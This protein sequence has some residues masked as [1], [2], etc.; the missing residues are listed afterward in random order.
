MTTDRTWRIGIQTLLL[1]GLLATPV[2]AC[3]VP[4]FRYALEQWPP[5]YFRVTVAHGAA[6]DD[7]QVAM[8]EPFERAEKAGPAPLNAWVLRAE[9]AVTAPRLELREPGADATSAP[10]WEAPLSAASLATLERSP[11]RVELARRL[12]AGDSVVWLLLG[13][14]DAAADAEVAAAITPLL[15]RLQAAIDLPELE[16]KDMDYLS[17]TAP[18]LELRFSLL[19][20]ARADAAEDI[21]RAQILRHA[22]D[23]LSPE[24]LA[25][26][27]LVPVFGRGRAL[28]VMP[29]KMPLEV[30]RVEDMAMFMCGPCS[31]QVKEE[32]PGFDL[33]LAAGWEDLLKGRFTLAEAIPQLASP[34][35]VVP[36]AE[37]MSRLTAESDTTAADSTIRAATADTS[38]IAK[39]VIIALAGFGLA[40]LLG[41]VWLRTRGRAS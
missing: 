14:E 13:G 2:W 26:P 7:A 9:A 17:E 29:V 1:T 21:L 16:A 3:N 39:R 25:G 22:A 32:N 40:V 6:L 37:V 10:L 24:E 28:S 23:T 19:Q 34:T 12:L 11:A 20:V 35:Q 18:A 4:V 5:D 15:G 8:L 36:E 33:L 31:C 41:S 38:V 30:L 27:L